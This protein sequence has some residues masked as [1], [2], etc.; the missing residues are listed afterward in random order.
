MEIAAARSS[1]GVRALPSRNPIGDD[2]RNT[3]GDDSQH[4]VARRPEHSGNA[5]LHYAQYSVCLYQCRFSE[6]YRVE[7]G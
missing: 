4:S 3:A 2:S 5:W 6:Q 7:S 1:V